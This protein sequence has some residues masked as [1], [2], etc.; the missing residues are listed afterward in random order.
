MGLFYIHHITI[1]NGFKINAGLLPTEGEFSITIKKGLYKNTEQWV[2]TYLETEF[3]NTIGNQIPFISHG[4]IAH[5]VDN[6]EPKEATPN[7]PV[8]IYGK[9]FGINEHD[10]NVYFG[11]YLA[12]VISCQDNE[13]IVLAPSALN[14]YY[15][16][17]DVEV[18]HKIVT[19]KEKF[20]GN[21]C[22]KQLSDFPGG[23]RCGATVF[24]FEES[25][26]VCLGGNLTN[27]NYQ[28]VYEFK[29]SNQTWEKKSDFPGDKR[30]FAVSCIINNEAYLGFGIEDN[31][32]KNDFWK[33]SLETDTWT[34]LLE[35]SEINTN[36]DIHF[37]FNNELYIFQEFNTYK[38]IRE[39]NYFQ[40][41]PTMF[42]KEYR[43]YAV[44]LTHKEKLYIIGGVNKNG[45]YIDDV[46]CFNPQTNAW[47]KKA[48]YPGVGA[49]GLTSFVLND[50]IYVGL[51][52]TTSYF[53]RFYEYTPETDKWKRV[54]DFPG[55]SRSHSISFISDGKA[56]IGTGYNRRNY[57]NRV[58]KDF[59]VFDPN[60]N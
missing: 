34:K 49:K 7:T 33:Y 39:H 54:Q 12:D 16:H 52:Q 32:N 20:K 10:I 8:H 42:P 40:K 23:E 18:C 15:E 55:D 35:D 22:W 11:D 56:Y 6:F 2:S 43:R 51:G 36:G 57:E 53:R 38:Y 29:K 9:N 50:K 59:W 25:A 24:D 17:I 1:I 45:D 31:I 46:W 60:G 14:D 48:D 37:I 3:N 5:E 4:G 44:A 26:M 41:Q 21:S 47:N 13:I 30:T 27:V 28:D 58:Y 19:T